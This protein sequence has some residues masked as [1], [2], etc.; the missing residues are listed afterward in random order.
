MSETSTYRDV[1]DCVLAFEMVSTTWSH[2]KVQQNLGLPGAN[3]QMQEP[4]YQGP[5][6]MEIDAIQYKGG[7]KGGKGKEKGKGKGLEHGN[8][9]VDG[10]L[11]KAGE[12]TARKVARAKTKAGGASTSSATWTSSSS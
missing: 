2:Q 11:A 1:K 12:K 8:K 6:P 9:V 4:G 5:A 10:R 3:L 7:K